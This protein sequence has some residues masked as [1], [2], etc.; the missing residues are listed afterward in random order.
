MRSIQKILVPTDF[1]AHARAAIRMAADLAGKYGAQVTLVHVYEPVAYTLPDGFVLH[2]PN[3]LADL[4]TRLA[5]QLGEEAK[6]AEAA[7]ARGV[8]VKQLQGVPSSE[9]VDFAKAN[10]YDLIVMGT[11]GR[12]GLAHALLGSVAERVVRKAPCAVLT[13]RAQDE[14]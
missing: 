10:G 3:Q 12:T 9:I 6:E 14:T 1:S 5:K 13:L 2:T 8:E 11:H 7:G 4:M